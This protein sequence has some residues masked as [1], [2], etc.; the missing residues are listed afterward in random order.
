MISIVK[1]ILDYSFIYSFS[2]Q[3]G[4]EVTWGLYFDSKL[5]SFPYIKLKKLNIRWTADKMRTVNIRHEAGK[6]KKKIQ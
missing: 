5:Y 6:R 4:L 2:N 1:V 3:F